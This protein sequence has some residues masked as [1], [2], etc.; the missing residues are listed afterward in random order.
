MA[1]RAQGATT[2]ATPTGVSHA[3]TTAQRAVSVPNAL[4][5]ANVQERSERTERTERSD[6][7]ERFERTDSRRTSSRNGST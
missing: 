6:R 4:S 2:S 7:N 1:N 3:K 5:A